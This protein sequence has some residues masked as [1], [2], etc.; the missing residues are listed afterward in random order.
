MTEKARSEATLL[1]VQLRSSSASWESSGAWIRCQI[2][3]FYLIDLAVS[4]TNR[5][6]PKELWIRLITRPTS[7]L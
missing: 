5:R 1:A 4:Y 2:V 6:F 7:L 3:S